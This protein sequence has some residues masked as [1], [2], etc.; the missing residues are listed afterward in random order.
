METTGLRPSS[1]AWITGSFGILDFDTL[2]TIDELE[3]ESRPH[4]W[5]EEAFAIHKIRRS[6]AM[7]F[8]PRAET[9]DRLLEWIPDEPLYFLNHAKPQ[10]RFGEFYHFDFAFLKM[11]FLYHHDI[12][13]F[14]KVLDP[15]RIISTYTVGKYLQKE[16]VLGVDRMRLSDLAT[17]FKIELNHHN[18]K[19]DRL[20]ME[21][22]LRRFR[23]L[24][25]TRSSLI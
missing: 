21:N 23:E 3:L 15:G 5:N 13:K 14:R 12:Y 18:A 20:A 22:I 16:G 1:D 17:Y 2:E 25:K 10:Q 6:K 4:N 7:K 11:D 24:E 19:S 9:L 8:P